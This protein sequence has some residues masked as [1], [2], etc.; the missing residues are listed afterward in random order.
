MLQSL[1][2]GVLLASEMATVTL[3][4]DSVEVYYAMRDYTS[5]VRLVEAKGNAPM[6]D[7]L[8]LGWSYYRL[9]DMQRSKQAFQEGLEIAP[10]SLEL[11]NGMAFAH[12]RLGEA[13]EAEAAF[14]QVLERSP[15]RVESQRGLAFVLFTTERFEECLPSF[16]AF[17]RDDPADTEAE[18]YLVK[19]VDGL[20]TSWRRERRTPAQMVEAA[21]QHE[22]EGNRRT[23][24]EMFQWIVQVNPF[25]PGARL[26]LG[27]LGPDFGHEAEALA[28]LQ[29]LLRENAA[30]ADARAALARLHMRAGRF[31][32]AERERQRLV[33]AHPEDPRGESIRQEIS[34]ARS[35]E[36]TP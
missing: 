23:A 33:K 7:K 19:S 31:Q 3:P 25:H 10:A 18:Y 9:G 36:A 24:F 32:D 5:V 12:Y 34:L 8:L 28:A 30:D 26:G 21:W 22:T 27:K 2:C 4:I 14:R 6:H 15:E 17:L 1:F 16:D 13:A 29:S 20:L 11:L 35:K